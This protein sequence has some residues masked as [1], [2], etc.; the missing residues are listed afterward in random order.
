M[1]WRARLLVLVLTVV[2][3]AA[4]ATATAADPSYVAL[5]DSF[6]AG[7]LIP[8]QIQPYGCLKSDHNYPHLAA[9][10]LKWPVFRDASCSG[11]ETKHMTQPQDVDPGPNPPQF[12]SLDRNTRI[13][14]VGIGGNDIG[15]SEI[16]R[17]CASPTTPE[18]H[19][20]QDHYVVNGRDE[21]SERIAATAPKIAAVLQGIRSR[22]PKASIDLVNYLPILPDQGP[23]CWPQMPVA[24][25]D[26]PYLRAK[27]KELNAML[28]Q[29]AAANG[30]RVVD[31]YRAGI[32][33]DA[34][35]LP[36]IRWV[37]PAVPVNAAAPFHPNLFGMQATAR[38][39]VA[40]AGVK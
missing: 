10:E 1:P 21:I 23:G 29:Q 33:H 31:A 40:V 8:L 4:P 3:L 35:Q 38:E 36:G 37:E 14:S 22:A 5:G 7:P 9:P 19:P 20:C 16:I 11:A 28:G 18:G 13:V 39:L 15:F 12:D 6:T 24:D 17:N 25:A 34:C 32:G 2:A 27:E 26:V 30:A